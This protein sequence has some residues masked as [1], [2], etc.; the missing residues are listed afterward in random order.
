MHLRLPRQGVFVSWFAVMQLM[1]SAVLAQNVVEAWG[2]AAI[3]QGDTLR[4]KKAAT[5]DGLKRCIEQVV[6]ITVQNDFSAT[7]RGN[8]AQ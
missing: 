6:G 1:S 2:E 7:L 8:G 4:A 3:Q 5:A